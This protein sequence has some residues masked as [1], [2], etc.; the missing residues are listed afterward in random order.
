MVNLVIEA[1][2]D[3]DLNIDEQTIVLID[4]A[5]RAFTKATLGILEG[6]KLIKRGGHN[7][8]IIQSDSLEVVKAIQG[9]I[10]S[11]SALIRQIQCILSQEGKWLLRY[12]LREHNQ[13]VDCLTKLALANKEE[14]QTFDIPLVETLA[15][16][17]ADKAKGIFSFQYNSMCAAIEHS[18]ATGDNVADKVVAEEKIE[19][20]LKA[21][22]ADLGRVRAE[23]IY[24]KGRLIVVESSLREFKRVIGYLKA[25]AKLVDDLVNLVIEVV[26]DN[27]LNIDEQITVLID[28]AIRA[29]TQ[30]LNRAQSHRSRP[31]AGENGGGHDSS[32]DHPD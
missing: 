15:P 31:A 6:L 18:H 11:N 7:K 28:E 22:Q 17:E 4:E 1:L 27:D 5:T 21:I 10:T 12:I 25:K 16:L 9:S 20:L 32:S 24:T 3:N 2:I 30:A 26:I 19:E 14:L 8:V 29:F 13:V 23:E